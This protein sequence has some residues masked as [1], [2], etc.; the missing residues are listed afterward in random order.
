MSAV[1][2]AELFG[3]KN[4]FVDKPIAHMHSF[5]LS[6]EITEAENYIDWFEKIRTAGPN[7]I[8]RI[9]INSRGGHLET[10]I[11]FMQVMHETDAHIIAS[12][13]GACMSAATLIFLCADSY[14]VQEHSMFMFHNYSAGSI[15]KGGEMY[16]EVSYMKK[17]SD[18]FFRKVYK[19]FLSSEEIDSMFLGKDLWLTGLEVADRL[20][21]L[22]ADAETDSDDGTDESAGPAEA[23]EA[24]IKGS[25]SSLPKTSRKPRKPVEK[26]SENT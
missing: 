23:S 12:V 25:P 18:N 8:I 13:E 4:F 16:D 26:S 3:N 17:W 10:A 9:H 2:L 19:D 22:E 11:Q 5:Y 21:L 15:G 14:E 6:G 7:D 20:N 24:E 1:N